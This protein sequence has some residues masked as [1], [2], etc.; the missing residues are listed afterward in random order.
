MLDLHQILESGLQQAKAGWKMGSF[1]AIAQFCYPEGDTP[2]ALAAPLCQIT[3]LGGIR[4]ALLTGVQ[5]VAYEMLSPKVNR[6]TQALALCLPLE[7][8]LMRRRATLTELGP[9]TDALREQDQ[10]GILFDMGLAQPQ[11]DFCIRTA[12]PQLLDVLRANQGRAITD[13][14]NPAMDAIFA[15]HPH[16]VTLTRLGRIEVYQKI[17][18]T[19]PNST[20]PVGPHTHIFYKMLRLGRSHAANTPIPE[21][22]VPCCEFY[23]KSPVEGPMG[24]DKDFDPAAFDAFQNLLQVWGAP[25]YLAAKSDC[26]AGLDAKQ[27]PASM[28]EPSTRV[29][30]TGVRNGLRQWRRMHG[31]SPLLDQWC[32]VF[33]PKSTGG[34]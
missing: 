8:A 32:A 27:D 21:G 3:D 20:A 31:D 14:E 33:D 34:G 19:D 30:R 11:L 4:I 28:K 12:D 15:S 29:G 9:D 18:G 1:G 5:A 22:W 2:P 26:W 23:P 6:W 7:D 24:A 10:N 17:G 13:P 25:D 16:R